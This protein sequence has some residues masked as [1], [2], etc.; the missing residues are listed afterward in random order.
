[1]AKKEAN[2]FELFVQGAKIC[3]DAARQLQNIV[4]DQKDTLAEIAAIHEIEREG[5]L[6]YHNIY[7]QL[8][9]SFIT[10]IEREDI[11]QIA[12]YIEETIDR[13]DEVAIMFNMMSVT[14]SRLDGQILVGLIVTSCMSLLEATQEFRNFNKSKRLSPLL[15][16]I[17]H[18]EEEGDRLYQAAMKDLFSKEKEVLEVVKWKSIFSTME[19]VLD[20]VE[21]VADVMEGVIIKNS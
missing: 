16:E 11:I 17:N 8:H 20:G 4:K 18:I 14:K 5:D 3:C 10:P 12:R 21:N 15:V 9:H 1:M 19:D 7:D 2:Y 13:I 6:L